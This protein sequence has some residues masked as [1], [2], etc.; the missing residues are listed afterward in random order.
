MA[1]VNFFAQV[2]V[3]RAQFFGA[4][5]H[6]VLQLFPVHAQ[7]FVYPALFGDIGK[8]PVCAGKAPTLIEASAGK[9][10]KPAETTALN[11][12]T[13]LGSDRFLRLFL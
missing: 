13:N 4:H 3:Y 1:V 5:L 10:V 12:K 2:T 8:G 11:A 6:Q 7:L 9:D